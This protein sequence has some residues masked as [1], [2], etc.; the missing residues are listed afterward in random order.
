MWRKLREPTKMATP[1]RPAVNRPQKMALRC[2]RVMRGFSARSDPGRRAA[3]G[4]FDRYGI[5]QRAHGLP[6]LRRLVILVAQDALFQDHGDRCD[7]PQVRLASLLDHLLVVVLA[8]LELLDALLLEVVPGDVPGAVGLAGGVD[9]PDL[10]RT[11]RRDGGE[12]QDR[13]P[14]GGV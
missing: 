10:V 11:L 14:A 7:R 3:H 13:R 4:S 1:S 9:Q 5:G 2:S 8:R 6:F 12:P